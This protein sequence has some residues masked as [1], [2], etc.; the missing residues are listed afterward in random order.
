MDLSLTPMRHGIRQTWQ[1][2]LGRLL[3]YPPPNLTDSTLNRME[4]TLIAAVGDAFFPAVG[5]FPRSGREADVLGYFD[6]YL[7]RCRST[8][9]ALLH[10]LM[11]FTELSPVLFGPRH[12]P[13]TRL[14]PPEQEEFL[15]GAFHSSIYFRRVGFTS[16]RALMTMA[17][18]AH[19]DIARHIGVVADPDP[20]RLGAEEVSP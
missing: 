15:R 1:T 5:P 14:S 18:L 2:L 19:P 16:L 12:V 17:Y 3:P 10:L 8:E 4:Q 20:F 11:V 6:A 7:R 13:F 9:R